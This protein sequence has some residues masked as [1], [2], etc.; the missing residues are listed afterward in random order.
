MNT[1]VMLT[2]VRTERYARAKASELAS[3]LASEIASEIAGEIAGEPARASYFSELIRV[4]FERPGEALG[5]AV[6][7]A[8][9]HPGC[10][11]SYICS[12]IAA[13]LAASGAKVLLADAQAILAIAHRDGVHAVALCERVEPG[14]VWVLGSRQIEHAGLSSSRVLSSPAAVLE[15]LRHE[16]SH[17]VIDAPALSVSDDALTLSATVLGTVFVA[18]SARTEKRQIVEACRTFTSLGA[19]VFGSVYNAR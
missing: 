5:S 18:A 2:E 12:S 9:P 13:E 10:G 17:I 8:A 15:L 16:F 19:K 11:V 1:T 7:F 4:V 14:R 6:Q 3:E